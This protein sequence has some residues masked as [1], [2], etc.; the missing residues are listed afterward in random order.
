MGF[1][2]E[3]WVFLQKNAPSCRKMHFPTERCTFL[4]KNAVSCRRMH[5]FVL[6]VTR[7]ETAGN[8]RRFQCSSIKNASQL[9]QEMKRNVPAPQAEPWSTLWESLSIFSTAPAQKIFREFFWP[10]N[11]DCPTRSQLRAFSGSPWARE[12]QNTLLEQTSAE[13]TSLWGLCVNFWFCST[14]SGV[15]SHQKKVRILFPKLA[16]ISCGFFSPFLPVPKI[17]AKSTPES[18][19]ESTP[20]LKTVFPVVFL[21]ARPWFMSLQL[22]ART[23][24]SI[25]QDSQVWHFVLG[26]SSDRDQRWLIQWIYFQRE[27]STP[28]PLCT[29]AALIDLASQAGA[30]QVRLQREPNL[31]HDDFVCDI[32]DHLQGSLAKR[33]PGASRPRGPKKSEKCRKQS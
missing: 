14:D 3:K 9:S 10:Q 28:N 15:D 11:F 6:G 30:S 1:P 16:W 29:R 31:R 22:D 33:V 18:T 19:P 12:L 17:Q 23:Y 8:C 25:N 2:A 5:F 26:T 7:Q 20:I 27:K 21:G 32:V 13:E 4:Q 24:K